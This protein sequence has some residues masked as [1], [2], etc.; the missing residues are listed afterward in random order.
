MVFR[1]A[2]IVSLIIAEIGQNYGENNSFDNAKEF[3]LGK[4]GPQLKEGNKHVLYF[5]SKTI[6]SSKVD[7]PTVLDNCKIDN[8][9]IDITG[10]KVLL[11]FQEDEGNNPSILYDILHQ[12][13]LSYQT[14]E[15]KRKE[16]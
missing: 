1:T 9:T 2:M 6:L 16:K 11:V 7:L 15:D 4:L 14:L 5:Q 8:Y 10:D 3:V 13:S 12:M